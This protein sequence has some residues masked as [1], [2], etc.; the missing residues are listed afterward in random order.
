MTPYI[1]KGNDFSLYVNI[2]T[3]E[4]DENEQVIQEDFDLST[5]TDIKAY[6]IKRTNNSS[7]EIKYDIP[8]EIDG[9]NPSVMIIKVEGLIP[10]F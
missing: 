5:S 4:I 3:V 1:V 6:L 8:F 2:K 7:K 10:N 9:E